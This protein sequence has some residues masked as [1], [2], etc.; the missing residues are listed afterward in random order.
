MARIDLHAHSTASDGTLSP[1]ELATLARDKG[2]AAVALTDHDTTAGLPEFLEAGRRLGVETIPGCE[3]SAELDALRLHIL[4]LWLPVEP[5]PLSRTLQELM[6]YRHARNHVVIGKLNELGVDIRY[7]EVLAKAGNGSVGRPHFAQVLMDKGAVTSV[8]MAFDRFLG[9]KGK[10]YAPKRK[11]SAAQAIGLLRDEGATVI[12]AHPVLLGLSLARLEQEVRRLKDLGLDG[13]E[14]YYSEQ[15]PRAQASYLGLA[16]KLGLV[17]S[18][19][20][21]FHGAIK[22]AIS[23]GTGKGALNV[24]ES[25]L[26]ALKEHRLRQGLPVS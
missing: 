2:L 5:G 17:V 24:P 15:S 8:Q 12:L 11:L 21:D 20:S 26:R 25:V 10:A 13:I 4:G 3:V 19:G 9:P 14:A 1:T 6:D 18:G 23:L 16:A 7:E 22:P